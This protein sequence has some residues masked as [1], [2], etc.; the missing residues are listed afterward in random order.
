MANRS[1]NDS[2]LTPLVWALIGAAV[3]VAAP[4]SAASESDR[5]VPFLPS[6]SDHLGRQGFVRVMNHSDEAGDVMIVAIDDEGASY[7]PLTLAMEA[8]ETVHFN[9]GDLE[10]GNVRKG[11]TGSTGGGQSR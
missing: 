7:G 9:S 2:G 11:L 5:L 4:S 6:A 10:D 3:I 8:G 1:V